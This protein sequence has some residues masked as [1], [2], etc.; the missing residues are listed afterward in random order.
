MNEFPAPDIGRERLRRLE[1][2]FGRERK[3]RNNER[4]N[5]VDEWNAGPTVRTRNAKL[6]ANK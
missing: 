2:D 1:N 5:H 4:D 6:G 3:S